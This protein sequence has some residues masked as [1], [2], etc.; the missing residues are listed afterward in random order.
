MMYGAGDECPFSESVNFLN[1]LAIDYITEITSKAVNIGKSGQIDVDD[2]LYLTRKDIKKYS[3]IK[4]LIEVNEDLKSARRAFDV[5]SIAAG[6]SS[7]RMK[8]LTD[9]EPCIV[10]KVEENER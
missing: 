2:V 4:S 5:N 9:V 6:S 10:V 3:R 7:K 8:A 1:D